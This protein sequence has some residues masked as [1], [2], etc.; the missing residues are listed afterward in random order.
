MKSTQYARL[1]ASMLLFSTARL[2]AADQPFKSGS[3]GSYGPLEINADTTLDMP[4]DGIFHC[5]TVHIGPS[6]STLRFNKNALNTPVYLLA[7][8]DVVIEGRG[9][10]DVS[11]EN[12]QGTVGGRG[13]PGGFDGGHA[14]FQGAGWGD[15]QGPGRGIANS[16]YLATIAV[17]AF[18]TADNTNAYGNSLLIPLIGGSGGGSGFYSGSD[19]AGAGVPA[20]AER[21]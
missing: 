11:G 1:I 7:T 13:G 19:Q 20:G 16:T 10:I 14:A 21:F 12:R 9:T 18:P 8:G 4:P 15:G 17:F 2:S 6:L 3:N 5:T